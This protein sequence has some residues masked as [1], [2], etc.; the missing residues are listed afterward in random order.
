MLKAGVSVTAPVTDT[1]SYVFCSWMGCASGV[2]ET[3][4]MTLN[5]VSGEG[6]PAESISRSWMD[7][8]AFTPTTGFRMNGLSSTSWTPTAAP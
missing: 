3:V 2:L 8:M 5:W 4:A 6:F 7:P 1:A